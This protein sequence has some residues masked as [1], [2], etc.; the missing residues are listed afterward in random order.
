MKKGKTA[1]SECWT[2]DQFME[3][4]KGKSQEEIASLEAQFWDMH[5]IN[6]ETDLYSPE[7]TVKRME[8]MVRACLFIPPKDEE[9]RKLR[10][11]IGVDMDKGRYKR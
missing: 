1:S 3:K 9:E 7:E 6:P 5:G 4:C 11:Q 2:H 8:T 10:E